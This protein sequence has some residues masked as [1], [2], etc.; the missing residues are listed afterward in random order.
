MYEGQATLALNN[1]VKRL[2]IREQ[3]EQRKIHLIQSLD[4]INRTIKLLDENP[5]FEEIHDAISK[6]GYIG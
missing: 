5:H 1:P 3:L 2:P 6:L 4:D